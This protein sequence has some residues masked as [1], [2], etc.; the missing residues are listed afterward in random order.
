MSRNYSMTVFVADYDTEKAAAIREAAEE[1]WNFDD[2]REVPRHDKPPQL[3]GWGDD[4]LC[5]GETEDEF[6][7]RLAKA[8]WRANGA[9]CGVEVHA[10]F[11]DDLPREVYQP[12]HEDY[13]RL[14]EGRSAPTTRATD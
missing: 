4:V 11:L 3:A 6:A 8:I 13:R 7:D 9:Y 5:G 10:V 12:D 1:E 14:M 2:W